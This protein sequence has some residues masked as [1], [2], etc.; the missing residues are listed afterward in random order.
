MS[1]YLQNPFIMWNSD[2]KCV[3]IIGGYIYEKC[4][5]FMYRYVWF[6]VIFDLT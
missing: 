1:E 2:H 5:F 4:L 3:A 6:Q